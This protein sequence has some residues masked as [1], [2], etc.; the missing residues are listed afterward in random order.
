MMKILCSHRLLW[1]I[2]NVNYMI[3]MDHYDCN[4]LLW[5]TVMIIMG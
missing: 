4:E 3:M 1:I 2:T 5:V